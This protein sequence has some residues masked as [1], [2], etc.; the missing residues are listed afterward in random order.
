MTHRSSSIRVAAIVAVIAASVVAVPSPAQATDRTAP[1][2]PQGLRVIATTD[3][4]VSLAW[5]ASTDASGAVTYRVYVDGRQQGNATTAAVTIGGLAADTG[6]TFAV[7]AVDRAGNF[8]A[9]GDPI[10]VSTRGRGAGTP[11]NLRVTGVGYDSID[12]AWDAPSGT[13]TVYYLI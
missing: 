6:Y 10:T 3:S 1:T 7:R 4:A 5:S 2:T 12:L 11:V 8:S 13:S 9:S